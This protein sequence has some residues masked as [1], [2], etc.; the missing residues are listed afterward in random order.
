MATIVEAY[1]S[2]SW[3]NISNYILKWGD[4]DILF[5]NFNF[6]LKD[7]IIN[8]VFNNT[9]PNL[10]VPLVKI[11]IKQDGK[12]IFSGYIK[13]MKYD[14]FKKEHQIIVKSMIDYLDE[15]PIYESIYKTLFDVNCNPIEEEN[16]TYCYPTQ[17]LFTYIFTYFLGFDVN[18]LDVCATSGIYWYLSVKR[19]ALWNI[20]CEKVCAKAS[21]RDSRNIGTFKD[22]LNAYLVQ[23]CL[24]LYWNSTAG[25]YNI[26][27]LD[28]INASAMPSYTA[29]S[30]DDIILSKKAETYSFIRN[31]VMT[32]SKLALN[33]NYEETGTIVYDVISESKGSAWADQN[34]NNEI[35]VNITNN[36]IQYV[37]FD[38]SSYNTD[39]PIR[40]SNVADDGYVFNAE[41]V[42]M[43]YRIP[44]TAL[45][46]NYLNL[47]SYRG[48]F[49]NGIYETEIE[50]YT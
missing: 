2:A 15:F 1:Y 21:G 16:G 13:T 33:M 22:L 4:F 40:F 10:V 23:N 45:T 9:T 31:P 5:S 26:H 35:S 12:I 20:G 34:Y 7:T 24:R 17:D 43:K 30:N 37:R 39:A 8:A 49:N 11:R 41:Y 3:N 28:Y 29:P 19:A 38:S 6:T 48:I 47:S 42:F 36:Y 25:E 44:Y 18:I 27:Y 32:R 50:L 46:A 14:E